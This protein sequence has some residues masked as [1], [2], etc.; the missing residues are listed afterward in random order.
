MRIMQFQMLLV[1]SIT[2]VL[3]QS[4]CI[5]AAESLSERISLNEDW[6]FH[7]YDAEE[8]ADGLIYD[9]RPAVK[10]KEDVA[11][12]DAMPTEVAEVEAT[13]TILKP[14][15]LP[16]GNDFIKDP[17]KHHVRP[18]G[19]PGSN[20]LFIQSDFDDSSWE[21]VNLPHDWAIKGPF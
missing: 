1:A 11:A 2:G 3:L 9:V 7:K 16:I 13:Q 19:N 4:K 6:R 8:K 21:S 18:E 10:D 12:A 15:I 17:A 14:W 20:F 5:T